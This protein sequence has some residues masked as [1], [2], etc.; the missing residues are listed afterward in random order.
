MPA[1]EGSESRE[2]ERNEVSSVAASAR[3]LE[4][5]QAVSQGGAFQAESSRPS[6]LKR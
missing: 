1:T 6:D 5:V 2:T 3:R 4:R